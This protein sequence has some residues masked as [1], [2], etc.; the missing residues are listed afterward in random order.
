MGDLVGRVVAAGEY[1]FF[2]D[3]GFH[4]PEFIAATVDTFAPCVAKSGVYVVE[5]LM[6]CHADKKVLRATTHNSSINK[7]LCSKANFDLLCPLSNKHG[8]FLQCCPHYTRLCVGTASPELQR[9][10]R[11]LGWIDQFGPTCIT[12]HG[13]SPVTTPE[14]IA[15]SADAEV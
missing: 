14:A 8:L 13:K 1:D 7:R 4:A 9:R 15:T 10:F 12:V 5:D 11:S 3:D 6:K 2:I